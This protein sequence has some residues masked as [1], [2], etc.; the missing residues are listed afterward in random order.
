[1]NRI[2]QDAQ[3]KLIYSIEQ[4]S[5]KI[6]PQLALLN[7]I[8]NIQYMSGYAQWTMMNEKQHTILLILEHPVNPVYFSHYPNCYVPT[9]NSG[10]TS[11]TFAD[12]V[13]FNPC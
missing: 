10:N 1:M 2:F 8:M 6:S 5:E 7:H 12:L 9:F 11:A 13:N 3:D 4:N